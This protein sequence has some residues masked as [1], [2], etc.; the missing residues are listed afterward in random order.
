MKNAQLESFRYNKFGGE[1]G[2]AGIQYGD[3]REFGGKLNHHKFEVTEP[4]CLSTVVTSTITRNTM[5]NDVTKGEREREE[6][7][8]TSTTITNSNNLTKRKQA[9]KKA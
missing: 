7:R 1:G 2:L 8:A 6:K 4:C 9:S 3:N 5:V